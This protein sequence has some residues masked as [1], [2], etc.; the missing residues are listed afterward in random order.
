MGDGL[1]IGFARMEDRAVTID[2]DT[3]KRVLPE[4]DARFADTLSF[5]APFV[6]QPSVL[7]NELGVQ[8][9]VFARMNSLGLAAEK[10]DLDLDALRQHSSF[11]PMNRSYKPIAACVIACR[12]KTGVSRKDD[13]LKGEGR[14]LQKGRRHTYK[15]A[16]FSRKGGVS[17][18]ENNK[19]ELM[20]FGMGG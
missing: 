5:L 13:V 9:L 2:G 10:W 16:R 3:E 11:G 6:R 4:I 7:G 1:R 20:E 15:F 17:L 19:T 8:E 14:P 18:Q 12:A